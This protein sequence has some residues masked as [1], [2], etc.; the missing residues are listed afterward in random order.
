MNYFSIF[1]AA[2]ADFSGTGKYA[3]AITPTDP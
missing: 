2:D 3:T 1:D